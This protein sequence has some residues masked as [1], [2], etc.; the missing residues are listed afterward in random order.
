[1]TEKDPVN[2]N[3]TDPT[4]RAQRPEAPEE[5]SRPAAELNDVSAVADGALPLRRAARFG[6]L[7]LAAVAVVSL[8]AWTIAAGSAGFYGALIGSVVGGIFLLTTVFTALATARTAPTTTLA[9]VLGSWL[10]KAVVLLI[11]LLVLKRMT[12]YSHPALGVTIIVA[13][14]VVLATETW[15]ILRTKTLYVS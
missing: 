7:A 2:V 6:S 5:A 15:A 10:V 13:L 12:F 8:V 4:E 1:M 9:V 11:V 14:V 3:E